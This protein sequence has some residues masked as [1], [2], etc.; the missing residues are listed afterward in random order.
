LFLCKLVF[1]WNFEHFCFL[2]FEVEV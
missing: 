2:G 1:D